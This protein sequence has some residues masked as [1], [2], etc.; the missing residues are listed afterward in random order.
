MTKFSYPEPPNVDCNSIEFI[1]TPVIVVGKGTGTPVLFEP[2]GIVATSYIVTFSL[3]ITADFS[4]HTHTVL[5]PVLQRVSNTSNNTAA[6]YIFHMVS[7]L[8]VGITIN[9]YTYFISPVSSSM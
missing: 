6:T 5:A 3:Y 2:E 8:S 4:P 9:I 7:P 1:V